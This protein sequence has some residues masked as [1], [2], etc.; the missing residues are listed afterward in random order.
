MSTTTQPVPSYSSRRLTL[1]DAE[2]I[3]ALAERVNGAD[4]AHR[5]VFS[6]TELLRLNREGRLISV[7]A[8]SSDGAVVG[9]FGL[10]RPD[11]GPIAETAAAMVLPEHRHHHVMEKMREL[12]EQEAA[13]AGL[14]GLSCQAVAQHVF[15][16]LMDD[17]YGEH[18][19]GVAFGFSSPEAMNMQA[20]T[21]QRLTAVLDFKYLRKVEDGMAC[22]PT[23]HQ[24]IMRKIYAGLGRNPELRSGDS[25][26]PAGGR[27][28][29][30]ISVWGTGEIDI[31]DAGQAC[32][33]QVVDALREMRD[34]S[35]VP[36][37]YVRIPLGQSG[38]PSVCEALEKHGFFFSGLVPGGAPEQDQL[39][40]QRL[41]VPF[42]FDIVRVENPLAQEIVVYS[43]AEHDRVFRPPL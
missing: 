17:H 13:T 5:E 8:I 30:S 32:V 19:I 15:T 26:L 1:D 3:P 28:E 6:P 11:L 9:Y 14:L 34:K 42:S 33:Q 43:A 22:V 10:E 29:A 37:F 18:P 21:H 23:H 20:V 31:V 35:Q 39:Q 36:V 12:L 2:A 25:H 16:Q 4:Y 38:G 7:V 41:E 27:I 24:A 40:L